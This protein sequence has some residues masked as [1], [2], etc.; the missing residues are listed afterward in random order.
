MG[1]RF[2]LPP[3]WLVVHGV[4]TGED[5]GLDQDRLI[6]RAIRRLPGGAGLDFT[7]SLYRYENLN[8]QAQSLVKSALGLLGRSLIAGQATDLLVDLVGDVVIK[9]RQTETARAIGEGL[10]AEIVKYY[11]QGRPLYLL[12]HSLGSIYAFDVVNELMGEPDYYR[13]GTIENWPVQ[14]L[15]TIGSPIGL[16]MFRRSGLRKIPFQ[17][18]LFRWLNLWDRT[19]PVVTGHVF[20]LANSDYE[21]AERFTH[22]GTGWAVQDR[23][24]DSGTQHLLSH[25]AY[26]E[27]RELAQDMLELMSW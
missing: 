21:I 5:A 12:G 18:E 2:E 6:D 7:A 4:Q 24:L 16:S 22:A 8:D 23:P 10:K 9:W 13:D 3:H 11:E 15:V 25:I 17:E 20:G 1:V 27:R 14:A 26:W 19:D